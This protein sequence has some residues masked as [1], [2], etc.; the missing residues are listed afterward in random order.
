MIIVN[1]DYTY[2]YIRNPKGIKINSALSKHYISKE[3]ELSEYQRK[4]IT[5]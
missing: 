2:C 4:L 3:E 5:K 1:M